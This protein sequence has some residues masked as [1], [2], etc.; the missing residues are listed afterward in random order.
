MSQ[1]AGKSLGW[2]WN[3]LRLMSP[4]E[5][6][7]RAGQRAAQWFEG[8]GVAPV[9][10]PSLAQFGRPWFNLS[11]SLSAA[12]R[13]AVL[14]EADRLLAGR[15]RVFALEDAPL[16]FPPRWNVDPLT[17]REAPLTHGKRLNYRDEARVGN[18][19]YLWEPS[20]HLEL[21]TLAQAWR[22]GGEPRY[23][24]A[25][26][27]LL[28]SWF[29]QCPYPLGVHWASSLELAIRLLNWSVAW[30]LLGGAASPLFEGVNGQALR[31]R[32]LESVWRHAE[33]IR[34]HLSK[35]SSANNHLLG[36]F[37]GLLFA[38][39]TWPCW[40]QA[41]SWLERGRRGFER[42]ALKQN[43]EDGVNREQALYYH[44][45]VAD[46]MLLCGLAAEAGAQGF[47]EPYWQRLERMLGFIAA[48]RDDGGHWPMI[49]DADDALML[50]L[51]PSP[52]F[53]PYASLLA[54]GARLFGRADFGDAADD[55]KTAWLLGHDAAPRR[56]GIAAPTLDFAQGG[57]W[58]LR[59]GPQPVHMVAD[60][61]PLGY[62][63]IAAHGH[64]DALAFTLS[65]AGREMLVDPGTYAYHTEPK[66]R[67][68]FRST[69]AHNTLCVDGQDQ[70]VIG[71]SFM[72]LQRAQARLLEI[73]RDTSGVRWSAEHDGYRRL[74]D[75]VLHR[76]EIALDNR[77]GSIVVTDQLLGCGRHEVALHWHLAEG[78][79]P[80]VQADGTLLVRHG[81]VQLQLACS[82][83]AQPVLTLH[84]GEDDPPLGW[85]S[86]RFDRKQAIWTA[87]FA[88]PLTAP[89]R[90]V[91]RL[92]PRVLAVSE[93]P[94]EEPLDAV[95]RQ[96]CIEKESPL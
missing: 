18:I 46:M 70:S 40:P 69:A 22:L 9:P 34:G 39:L 53:N 32:W 82:G 85:I 65:V 88:A 76:R 6:A 47:G 56:A 41:Q 96:P 74:R 4:S 54:S 57:Y 71:G 37:M 3:R 10:A 15:W 83:D 50:R 11:P 49:G 64:A 1:V 8:R 59:G 12:Q 91:T 66:W 2:Y 89:A 45:E 23:L 68:Y 36:E 30:H 26:R 25:C 17:G 77:D 93:H 81:P 94:S 48:L 92:V 90:L 84:R 73:R 75:G 24:E 52:R 31:A 13:E 29:D 67:N 7:W 51:D 79:E 5:I 80:Q 14:A 62:L 63:S 20:R 86:R 61:G 58:V 27:T 44:H 42:E 19:K 21:V 78:C 87:R 16:G 38:G 28:E 60:A 33:F 35:H 55:A 95:P 72:W 43:A